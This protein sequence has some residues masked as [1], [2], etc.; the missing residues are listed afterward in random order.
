[1]KKILYSITFVFIFNIHFVAA[2][3]PI[4]VGG[5][6]DY[7][8]YSFLDENGVPT[9]FQTDLCRSIAR[10]MGMKIEI[11]LTVWAQV[12]KG[13]EEGTIDLISGMFYSDER[14]KLYHFS[15]PYCIVSSVIFAR[16]N[17]PSVESINELKNKEIIVMGGEAMHD[18]VIK[19]ELTNK[20]LKGKTPGE[21]LQKL[22][23]GQGDYAL[24]AQMP[25]LYWIKKLGLSNVTTMG[26]PLKPF[27]DC[28]SVKKGNILL[29]S[30]FT[31]G[32]MILY[33]TGEYQKLYEKWFDILDPPKIILRDILKYTAIVGIPLLFLLA[34]VFIWSWMLRKT[35]VRRTSELM[36]SQ[37]QLQTLSDNLP[38]GYVYQMV[39]DNNNRFFKYISAGVEQMHG[40]S[41]KDIMNDSSLLYQ[42]IF[43]EDRKYLIKQETISR[44]SLTP[45]NVEVRY[46]KPSGKIK[47]LL[48]SS[49]PRKMS[50][51]SV[52]SDGIA[53]DITP[54]KKAFEDLRFSMKRLVAA[55][56]IAKLGDFSWDLQ[57]GEVLWSE[58]CYNLL[59][60]D[61]NE[62]INYEKVNAE[63]HHPEDLERITQWLNEAI[64]SDSTSLKPNEYRLI[65]KD[66]QVI[67]VHTTGVIDRSNGNVKLF[68]TL[69]DITE[70]KKFE[71]DLIN[72][73]ERLIVTLRS[74]GDGVITTDIKGNIVLINK[75]G[76]TLTGW[77]QHEAEGKHISEI[78]Y[79]VNEK[80]RQVCKNPIDK[81][82]KTGKIAGLA[83]NTLLISRDGIERIIADSGAPILSYDD[84][85]IG[86]VLVFRDMT[87]Q[88]LMEAEIQRSQKIES[89]GL[90]AGGI[91]HDFNNVLSVITGNISYALSS[92]NQYNELWPVLNDVQTGTKQAQ[93]LTQQLLTFSKGGVPIKSAANIRDVLKESVLFVTSGSKVRCDFE[94]SENLW[95]V[96]VDTGQINQAVTN[97]V[98]NASQ[99]M[100]DGGI[101]QIKAEN[102]IIESEDNKLLLPQG[103]YVKIS[104]KD[105]GTGISEKDI[106][107]IFDPYFTTKS[108]GNG[109]GLAT[110]YSIIKNHHGKITVESRLNEGTTFY[111]Y[112]PAKDIMPDT[113]TKQS[114]V[115]HKG[116][117]KVLVMDDQEMILNMVG[118]LLNRMG[119][120]AVFAK[121]GQQAIDIY[122]HAFLSGNPFVFVLLDLTVP[123]GMGGAQVIGELL[124]ID[125]DVKAIVSSG[126][127]NDPIMAS[128]QDYGFCGVIAKP[129]TQ[130]ELAK[131][132]E[133]KA[134]KCVT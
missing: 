82:L 91:A 12:R 47:W 104:I 122:K 19:H 17:S 67:F 63:I 114:S 29:L 28:F 23:S 131:T 61:T 57:T 101:I 32:L 121:D 107:N 77:Y 16:K 132:L 14:A 126:Y 116:Q 66:G 11:R 10:V 27:K 78:F 7:P 99:A 5:E 48:M 81:V 92:I 129:F 9:G 124:Q 41:A 20:I 130:K 44:T 96:S 100:P 86:V 106:A 52:V 53:I 13:L 87:Q 113:D 65:R 98:I 83:N 134:L 30:Q 54:R 64:E 118:R 46:Q 125:P 49:S 108:K 93:Q 21:V 55:Q 34:L 115:Q 102:I 51:Q 39:F 90:L 31:E 43:E 76:E 50:N 70:R 42:Q 127:S 75:V 40:L 22:A 73:K 119:Y 8:P 60:Y 38:G 80:T 3:N 18:Y 37:K 56:R 88:K 24:G 94:F 112:L 95:I 69:Q 123:G 36:E 89:I 45:F 6:L 128:Y 1:M 97:I 84:T 72:E 110:T 79:I 15:P 85:I 105:N 133:S 120:E 2:K 109:L 71:N 33:Q 25:G 59:K 74:I 58:G 4:I 103:N 62:T 68:A 26:K 117:G 35:V 111:I